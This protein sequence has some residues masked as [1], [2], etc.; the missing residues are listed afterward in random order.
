NGFR[1]WIERV[2]RTLEIFDIIRIDHF[3]GFAAS[4]EIPG[5][6]LTAERGQWVNVPGRE[7][8]TAIKQSLGDLPII[9]E[10][11]GGITPDVE[12]LRDDF[13]LPGMRIL[14]FAFGGGSD[15]PY[16]PHNYSRRTVAYTA[17]H[18]NDPTHG[19]FATAPEHERHHVRR[20]LGRL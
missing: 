6:D 3:R 12:A 1:W 11:L 17:T 9:A 8:F 19:W 13:G 14:Q 20:S 4:W 7:L 16:L 18:D 10:D 2:R 15:N 5:G